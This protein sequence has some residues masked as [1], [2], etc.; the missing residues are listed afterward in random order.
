MATYGQ[1]YIYIDGYYSHLLY[2][3]PSK[4]SFYF[5]NSRQSIPPFFN[6]V[7]VVSF[8][9]IK[10]FLPLPWSLEGCPSKFRCYDALNQFRWYFAHLPL[11]I[12]GSELTSAT[13]NVVSYRACHLTPLSW[14]SFLMDNKSQSSADGIKNHINNFNQKFIFEHSETKKLQALS[15]RKTLPLAVIWQWPPPRS[16]PDIGK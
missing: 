12:A 15:S 7:E 5:Y 16:N 4:P 10:F 14:S 9:T 6:G 8:L 11:W 1:I 2:A 13:L 3:S